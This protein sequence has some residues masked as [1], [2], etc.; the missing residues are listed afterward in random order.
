MPA[1]ATGKAASRI[2]ATCDESREERR[3]S[4]SAIF[5]S[6]EARDA[7]REEEGEKG[8][9]KERERERERSTTIRTT[10]TSG[11]ERNDARSLLA[12]RDATGG[13]ES[14]PALR[15]RAE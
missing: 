15:G 10:G 2:R 12:G 14:K 5:Q 7:A 8:K 1:A 3:E 6:I 13:I 11:G 9:E 4:G